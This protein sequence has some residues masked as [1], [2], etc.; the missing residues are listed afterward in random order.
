MSQLKNHIISTFG[1]S[2]QE[3]EAVEG[4]FKPLEIEKG[5]FFLKQDQYSKQLGFVESGILREFLY[6]ND[7]EI[8]KWF[9]TPGYF[10]VD[11]TGFM[12]NQKSKVSY[13]AL[14]DTRLLT[15]SKEDYHSIGEKIPAW[16]KLE[17]LFLTKCFSVLEN[18]VIAHLAMNAEERYN[19]LFEFQ[20]ALFNQ[21]P[22]NYLASMLGMTPE[23]LSRIRSKHSKPTS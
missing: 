17:K 21:V 5:A 12:H 14:T 19:Q 22:L 11:L 6:I 20:P 23:T 13:Q 15:I 18:R 4:V 8:T 3:F 1:F 7:K 2:T 16:D 9:S 10:A